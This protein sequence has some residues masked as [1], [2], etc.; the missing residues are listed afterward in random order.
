MPRRNSNARKPRHNH[1]RSH[2]RHHRERV[3]AK[4]WRA[5]KRYHADKWRTAHPDAIQDLLGPRSFYCTVT[6]EWVN[7][8]GHVFEVPFDWGFKRTYGLHQYG[9][10]GVYTW[11]FDLPKGKLSDHGL[12][13]RACR[14]SICR[15]FAMSVRARE[16]DLWR[17]QVAQ[18]L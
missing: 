16:R 9:V 1:N 14:C 11:P 3:I 10:W 8:K 7:P 2:H 18:D 5:A 12:R 15:G 17:R 4:R 6:W 13:N